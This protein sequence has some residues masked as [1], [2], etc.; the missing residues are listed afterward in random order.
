MYAVLLLTYF[1]MIFAVHFAYGRQFGFPEFLMCTF[2][3]FLVMGFL[4]GMCAAIEHV[5]YLHQRL[6]F[7]SMENEKLL[8]GMH[9]G[10]LIL[11]KKDETTMFF[12]KSASKVLH[13]LAKD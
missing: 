13:G 6:N 11:N 3:E 1:E 12:N 2:Y 9:E 7:T 5:Q 8:N 10:L 4:L